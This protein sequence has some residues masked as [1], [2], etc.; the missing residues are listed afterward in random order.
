MELSRVKSRRKP[1][2]AS[3]QPEKTS[4]RGAPSVP[5]EPAVPAAQ[6]LF[7]PAAPAAA[8]DLSGSPIALSRKERHSAAAA[9]A[10][11]GGFRLSRRAV[12]AEDR[13]SLQP[14]ETVQV[15]PV[16]RLTKRGRG[17]DRISG[18]EP[19]TEASSAAG[20]ATPSRASS[21]PSERVRLSKMFV[22]SLIVVFLLL[23]V[24][25]LWWGIEGAPEL[26]TLWE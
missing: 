15:P 13:A 21:Y 7:D 12:Q 24:S 1:E 5:A 23:L 22:N 19:G 2:K 10:S 14:A 25:L 20:E 16:K 6:N 8:E 11:A 26:R 17:S 3:M 4:K 18:T 9:K